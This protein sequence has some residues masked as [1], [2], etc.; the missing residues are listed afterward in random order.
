M[1]RAEL[2]TL[3]ED[4]KKSGQRFPVV[5]MNEPPLQILIDGRNRL[6]AMEAVGI[7]VIDNDELSVAVERVVFDRGWRTVCPPPPIEII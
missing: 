5:I 2:L 1:S 3:G 7:A 4:I 6:D